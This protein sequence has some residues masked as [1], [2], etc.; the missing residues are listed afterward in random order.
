M[1]F[2]HSIPRIVFLTAIFSLPAASFLYA[3]AGG[4]FLDTSNTELRII[5][6]LAWNGDENTLRYRVLVEKEEE[7]EYREV[8]QEFI[9]T[10]FIEVSLPPGQYRFRVVPYDYLNQPGEGSGWVIFEILSVPVPVLENVFPVL[11]YLDNDTVHEIY[12]SGKNLDNNTEI[13]LRHIG[14]NLGDETVSPVGMQIISQGSRIRLYFD[15]KQLAP[16]NYE[17]HV[18]NLWRRETSMGGITF[19]YPE[20]MNEESTAHPDPEETFKYIKPFII[21][22]SAAWM[23]LIPVYGEEKPFYSRTL[24]GS[25]HRLALIDQKPDLFNFGLELAVSWHTTGTSEE[26][27]L[28][29]DASAEL[30][31]LF[32][33]WL[34]GRRIALTFRIGA[35]LFFLPDN[36]E[37]TGLHTN[38]GTSF[39]WLALEHLYLEAGLDYKH[40]FTGTGFGCFRPWIGLGWQF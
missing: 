35:G 16:G 14:G 32:R 40:L 28:H 1:A 7:K 38:L 22:F 21:S 3:Q 33:K 26:N 6:R 39:L 29:H 24:D 27:S 37:K 31:M 10:A 8:L 30:N 34:P 5:Q 11:F 12:I 15:N 4:Y 36:Q 19:A 2:K 18:R 17:I 13:S 20:S 9:A 25:S 23:P